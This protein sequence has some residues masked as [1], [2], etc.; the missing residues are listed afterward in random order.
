VVGAERILATGAITV[1]RS[2]IATSALTIMNI[3]SKIAYF[4]IASDLM[5]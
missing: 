1:N 2:A 4:F 5:V 3:K